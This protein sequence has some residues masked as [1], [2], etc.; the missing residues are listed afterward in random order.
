MTPTDKAIHAIGIDRD[1]LRDRCEALE[2][3]LADVQR[4]LFEALQVLAA[5]SAE[6]RRAA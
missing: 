3:E 1:Y 4:E 6:R 2:A 5:M